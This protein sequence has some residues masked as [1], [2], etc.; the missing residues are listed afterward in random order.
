M[1]VI[2]GQPANAAT[3]NAAFADISHVGSGG[4]AHASATTSAS[5]FMSASDKTKLD[6]IV[7]NTR[8]KSGIV[9][10]ASFSGNPKTFTVT[11]SSAMPSTSYSIAICG[12][13]SR[14]W[15]F[16]SKTVNGFT[17]SSNANAALTG[18]VTWT[19]IS[20]GEVTK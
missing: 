10:G 16:S 6:G 8:I 7:V 5:G 4:S 9:A 12:T 15:S 3:F 1:A 14:S 2:N 11:F 20:N 17:I 18:E 13:S 19:C